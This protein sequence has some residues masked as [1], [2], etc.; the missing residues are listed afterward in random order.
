MPELANDWN[1]E[2]NSKYVIGSVYEISERNCY[3]FV[4]MRTKE[5]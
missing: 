5:G 1:T 4:R 2:I 3:P